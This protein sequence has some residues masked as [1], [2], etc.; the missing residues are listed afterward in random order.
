MSI[1][2]D[3]IPSNLLVPGVYTETNSRRAATG[4]STLPRRVLLVGQRLSTGAVAAGVPYQIFSPS[5][6][7]SGSG[8]G[9][10]LAEMAH[11]AKA[12]NKYVEMWG[13]GLAD[14]GSGVPAWPS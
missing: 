7:E 8:P 6:A 3:Q 9:S 13:I 1:V 2:F 12:A 5:D 10:M 4:T 11:V 14:N